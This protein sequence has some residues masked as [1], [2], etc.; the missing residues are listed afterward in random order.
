[1]VDIGARRRYR[2]SLC[3]AAKQ[4]F[5]ALKALVHCLKSQGQL[6]LVGYADQAKFIKVFWWLAKLRLTG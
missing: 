3:G 2:G 4:I 1:M 6:P 5:W